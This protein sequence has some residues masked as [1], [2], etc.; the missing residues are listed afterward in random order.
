VCVY[1]V[2]LLSCVVGSCLATGRNATDCYKLKRY[3]CNRPWRPIGLRDVEFLDNRLTDGGEVVS[4]TPRLP[5]TPRK[6]PATHFY[7]RLSAARRI[8]S[9]EKSNKI[10]NRTRDLPACSI[11][12]Q[13]TT[14]PRVLPPSRYVKSKVKLSLCL[15]N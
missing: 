4:L 10:G 14:L 8:R 5:F 9:I 6:I 11:V 7:E 12:P 2:F 15:T 13:P 1:S 3:P